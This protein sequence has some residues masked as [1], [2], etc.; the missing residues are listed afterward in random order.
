VKKYN[1]LLSVLMVPAIVLQAG[2]TGSTCS[3]AGGSTAV[4]LPG[5]VTGIQTFNATSTTTPYF[6][7]V[8]SVS[9]AGVFSAGTTYGAWCTNP[10]GVVPGGGINP[11]PLPATPP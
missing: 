3:G 1:Y 5:S 11:S 6:F 9:S 4:T 2:T 8:S 10:S 7:A